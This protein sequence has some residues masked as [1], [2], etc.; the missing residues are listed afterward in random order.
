MP[1]L[2]NLR[3]LLCYV[4]AFV[5][6]CDFFDYS[7]EEAAPAVAGTQQLCLRRGWEVRLRISKASPEG[8]PR[9]AAI[10]CS[11]LRP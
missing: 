6:M 4:Y 7:G 3:Q 2:K 5:G 8:W 10:V 11:A 1:D 9:R